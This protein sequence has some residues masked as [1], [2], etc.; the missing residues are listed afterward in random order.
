MKKYEVTVTLTKTW[1]E[2]VEARSIVEAQNLVEEYKEELLAE[3]SHNK[4]LDNYDVETV[5]KEE[6]SQ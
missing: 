3:C 5:I 2:E 4:Y 1:K 6:S